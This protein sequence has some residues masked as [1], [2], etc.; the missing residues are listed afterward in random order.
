MAEAER[1]G[2]TART[3][4]RHGVNRQ[5]L[6]WWRWALR[7]EAERASGPRF[8]PV[9]LAPSQIAAPGTPPAPIEIRLDDH[10]VLRV[11]AGS[12]VRYVAALIAAV[13]APC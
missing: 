5:R 8:L 7:R 1:C 10:I 4:E 12:D 13:R 3:A 6:A 11:P 9:T 2:S